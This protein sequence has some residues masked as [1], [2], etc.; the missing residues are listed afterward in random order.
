MSFFPSKLCL[1]LFCYKNIINVIIWLLQT[2]FLYNSSFLFPVSVERF[3]LCLFY[4]PRRLFKDPKQSKHDHVADIK[5]NSG[6]FLL[7]SQNCPFFE[8]KKNCDERLRDN[9][10]EILRIVIDMSKIFFFCWLNV[11]FTQWGADCCVR[12]PVGPTTTTHS[13]RA[14]LVWATLIYLLFKSSLRGD[15]WTPTLRSDFR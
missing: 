9:C 10:F 14:T 4:A 13:Y 2:P 11:V 6:L 7:F 1:P 3:S 15:S 8:E 12:S 5:R